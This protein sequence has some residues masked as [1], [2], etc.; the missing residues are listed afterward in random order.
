M[1]VSVNK[2]EGDNHM[3]SNGSGSV[4]HTDDTLG[5]REP[6]GPSGF[7]GLFANYYVSLCAAFAAV[8]ISLI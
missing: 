4:R 6:Y 2:V 7:R 3:I 8:C 5:D 1:D